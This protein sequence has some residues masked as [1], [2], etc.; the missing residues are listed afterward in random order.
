MTELSLDRCKV[1]IVATAS[2]LLVHKKVSYALWN[3]GSCN[4]I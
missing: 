4:E 1:K 2:K 3:R